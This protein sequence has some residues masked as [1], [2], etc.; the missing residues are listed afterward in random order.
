MMTPTVLLLAI[1]LV[2]PPETAVNEIVALVESTGGELVDIIDVA[3]V[4]FDQLMIARHHEHIVIGTVNHG[5]VVSSP[6]VLGV[7]VKKTRV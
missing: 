5:C 4:G 7:A 6:I 1:A 2:C 3:G